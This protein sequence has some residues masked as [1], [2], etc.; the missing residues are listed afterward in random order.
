MHLQK[1]LLPV[2]FSGSGAGAAHYAKTLACRFRSELTIVHVFEMQNVV[3]NGETGLPPGWYEDL[4]SESQ[5]FLDGCYADEFRD[6]PV[7]RLML[8]GDVARSIAGLA[9]EEHV[10]LIVMPTHGYG[11]FR[12]LLLGSVTAKLLHD[13]DCP[14]LT[15]VHLE[16]AAPLEPVNFRSIVCAV[17]FDAASEKAL[18][19]AAEFADEFH[20]R[21]TVVHALPPMEAGPAHYFD[22]ALPAMLRDIAQKRIDELQDRVG[23]AGQVVLERGSVAD[24]VRDAG[25]SHDAD[26]VVIGRHEK[27]GLLGRLRS[28]AYAIVRES[29]C[30]VVSV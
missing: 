9:H 6:M 4:R 10:D 16:E 29:P 27:A 30:P 2:D 12:R 14:I 25:G 24:V 1:I 3:F 28:N 15:G 23:T 22:Q 17:D 18:H 7:R 20:S 5:R 8:E 26:L 13:A 19:W 11:G 21:L